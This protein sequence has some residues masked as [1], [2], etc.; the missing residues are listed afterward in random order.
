M[1]VKSST[2]TNAVTLH[3]QH[4]YFYF[5]TLHQIINTSSKRVSLLAN[6]S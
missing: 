5:E 1:A 2:K 4:L 3:S 6:L